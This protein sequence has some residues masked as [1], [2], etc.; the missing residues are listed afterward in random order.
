[1]LR[2]VIFLLLCHTIPAHPEE[3]AAAPAAEEKTITRNESVDLKE[4]PGKPSTPEE[5]SPEAETPL[6]FTPTD[7]DRVTEEFEAEFP[8]D[9]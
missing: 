5:P 4:E 2:R 7:N 8:V 3:M 1:M 6:L 9:I